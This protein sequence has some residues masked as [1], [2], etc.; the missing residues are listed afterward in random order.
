MTTALVASLRS[1]SRGSLFTPSLAAKTKEML[2]HR[3][4]PGAARMAHGDAARSS[5]KSVEAGAASAGEDAKDK[6]KGTAERVKESAQST[7]ESGK[8]AAHDTVEGIKNAAQKMN[9]MRK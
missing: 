5:D 9:P 7:Y 1:L 8:Q 6:A 2:H 3:L 4:A